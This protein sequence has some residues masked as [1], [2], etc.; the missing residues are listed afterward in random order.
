ML[1]S[2]ETTQSEHTSSYRRTVFSFEL[3]IALQTQGKGGGAACRSVAWPH[4]SNAT[5]NDP[6]AALTEA[7]IRH[8]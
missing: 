1:I 3:Q 7:L 6:A 5:P 2:S 8:A 4:A